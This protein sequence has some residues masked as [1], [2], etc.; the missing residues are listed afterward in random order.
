MKKNILLSILYLSCLFLTV[1]GYAHI[2]LTAKPDPALFNLAL[3][4]I[5]KAKQKKLG[6]KQIVTIIDYSLPSTKPRLWVID[7]ETMKTLFHTHVSHGK[8]SGKNYA[9]KFSNKVDSYQSSIGLFVTT[10]MY[11][12]KY[13][14]SLNVRG[15]EKDFNSNAL[16]RRIVFHR[17]DYVSTKFINTHQRLGLSHG[18]FAL[19]NEVGIPIMETIANG[20]YVFAYYPDDGWLKDSDFLG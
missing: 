10:N 19:N 11:T 20:S 9:T 12:G 16:T 1:D 17:A 14:Q 4:A 13:G 8:G 15:I 18:C 5:N 6:S 2:N 7:L 3:K